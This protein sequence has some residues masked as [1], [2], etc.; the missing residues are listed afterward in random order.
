M[1]GK[2]TRRQA[3]EWAVQMLA[4][5]DLNPPENLNEFID[6]EW[7]LIASADTDG[8]ISMNLAAV[9]QLKEFTEERVAGVLKTRDEL[10]EIIKPL[11]D[12]WELHRLGT[13][14][15]SVLRMGIW[16][17]K[18]SDVP[19]PVVINE[20]VDL[21]NWFSSPKSRA[22]VNGILDRYAKSRA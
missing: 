14:E 12:G 15:R 22:L 21:A 16:E 18:Y 8:L 19:A 6:S 2:P 7:E 5:A 1:H 20:A 11:L 10:D 17:I 13:V 4:A 9:R 3:R